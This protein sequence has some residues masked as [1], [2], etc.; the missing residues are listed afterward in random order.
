MPA[1]PLHQGDAEALLFLCGLVRFLLFWKKH[2]EAS[3]GPSEQVKFA[4]YGMFCFHFVATGSACVGGAQGVCSGSA[5]MRIMIPHR[6]VHVG[7][8]MMG[9]AVLA[10]APASA[11]PIV[12]RISFTPRADGKG[13]VV[14]FHTSERIQAYRQPVTRTDGRL[15]IILFN[16][17]LASPF[18]IDNL[19]GPVQDLESITSED[20]AVFVFQL[21]PAVGIAPS[22][23]RDGASTDLLLSLE[24]QPATLARNAGVPPVR[25]ASFVKEEASGMA[26]DARERWRLDTI[27]ID[28]GHGGK[29]AGAVANGVR[30]KDVTL[31]V[32]KRLGAYLE[33]QLGVNIVYTREDDRF[34][35]L[36]ERG[37]MANEAGAKLFVSIHANA[38]ANHR[39]SGTETYFLGLHKNEAA[40]DVMERENS[41]VEFE[42]NPGQ[43]EEYDE[44]K[45]ILQTLAQSAYMHKSE[46]LAGLI[47]EQFA[48][49]VGRN[50]R[51]VK[52]AGFY[53]LWNASMPSILVE[54]GFVTNP[55]E[56]AFLKSAAGQDYL[57]SAIF[58]SIR[59]F[60]ERYERELNLV[61]S[62]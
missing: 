52:Q 1:T 7:L 26:T 22:V 17:S 41:V 42:D 62:R 24:Y 45:L 43:Y 57:A 39:A 28:A 21:D 38:A 14:R 5:I 29:D 25:Q 3:S 30:E 4:C 46:E 36:R 8:M 40:Q 59:A 15:E 9:L 44:S 54:L 11:R 27:V 32:A 49:R 33:E 12:E 18:A 6:K 60:K 56:A 13:Y 2:P 51:G 10:L 34:I 23:Y 37:R 16:T 19:A 48:E 31:A 55:Q 47:E 50:S 20:H 35:E 53:V 58:R 61:E